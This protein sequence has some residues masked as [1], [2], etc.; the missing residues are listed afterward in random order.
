MKTF[1]FKNWFDVLQQDQALNPE[2]KQAYPITIRWYLSYLKREGAVATIDSAR[3]F[4]EDAIKQHTPK[5][6]IAQRWKDALNWFFRFAP[7]KRSLPPATAEPAVHA[8]GE[9]E[10]NPYT[11]KRRSYSVTVKEYQQAV[12]PD[13]LIEDAV[14]L[15]RVRHMSYRSE[16]AYVG[17]LRRWKRFFLE[18]KGA[19]W[20]Q[21]QEEDLK[22]F[23]SHLAVKEGVSAGTQ[24]QALNAGV[25]FLR[26]VLQQELGD[27]SDYI[28]A[29]PS[30]YYPVVYSQDEVRRLLENLSGTYKIMAQL[31][32]GCG[33]RISELCRL[34]VQDI[35]F[36]RQKLYIR[37]GKSRKDRVVPLPSSILESLNTHLEHQKGLHTQDRLEQR[38]GVYLPNA[39]GKKF[40][41]AA[42]SWEW[43]WVFPAQNLAKDPRDPTA[44]KRRH[45]ILPGIYQQHLSE[46]VEK[47]GIPKRSNS[48]SLR[49]SFAT[50]HLEN[51]TNIRTV[52]EMLG[53]SHIETTMIYLHVMQDKSANTQ[54]PLDFI[55]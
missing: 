16:E 27:F 3:S 25:F 6:F 39:M 52:Q 29:N 30:K 55:Q 13:P 17:W 19:K 38:P 14:K 4:F 24:R 15:M 47:A 53:H 8:E 32:Y 43:F 48:H 50:H 9:T 26:E 12:G 22:N 54:S 37:Q 42:K 31:Q 49:H 41:Q 34:R 18:K 5:P 28:P 45:H 44:A 51:G 11:D 33:L 21:V 35:D 40:S 20:D 2:L 23:L 46:A 7:V 10:A 1:Y 36:E